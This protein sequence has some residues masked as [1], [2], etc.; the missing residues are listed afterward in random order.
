MKNSYEIREDAVVIFCYRKGVRYEVLIDVEDLDL[1]SAHKGTW[2]MGGGGRLY[3]CT[4][5]KRN[6]VGKYI[7]MHR[8]LL[9]APK[10]MDVDH[11]NGDT[12]D[13]RRANLRVVTHG[14]NMQNLNHNWSNNTSGVRGVF[15]N[16]KNKNWNARFEVGGVIYWVGSFHTK[17]EAVE[18]VS[19][20]RAA[21]MPYSPDARKAA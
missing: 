21:A 17:E 7:L 5:K 20:A 14:A 6:K 13:N 9:E 10:G 11:I 19:K 8:M 3:A 4:T 16:K 18:A 12:F 1:I 15:Y 2:A